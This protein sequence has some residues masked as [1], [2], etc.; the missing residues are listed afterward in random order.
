MDIW[1]FTCVHYVIRIAFAQVQNPTLITHKS[2]ILNF[3]TH[4]NTLKICFLTRPRRSQ[5]KSYHHL[6]WQAYLN[7]AEGGGWP[8][9]YCT[10]VLERVCISMCVSL[11][12][13]LYTFSQNFSTLGVWVT[14][15]WYKSLFQLYGKKFKK[16]MNIISLKIVVLFIL[17][18]FLNESLFQSHLG[19][20]TRKTSSLSTPWSLYKK[21]KL[22][23]P[24][25]NIWTQT[26]PYFTG[27]WKFRQKMF[28]NSNKVWWQLSSRLTC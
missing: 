6:C 22:V 25:V 24:C 11:I 16:H 2:I 19:Y 3:P 17:L 7:I 10:S 9:N 18:D 4:F 26:A 23:F 5:Q 12:I 21:A 8:P 1:Y 13:I 28:P 14:Y 27:S 15:W 20:A